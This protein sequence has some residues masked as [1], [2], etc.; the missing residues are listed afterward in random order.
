MVED[1]EDCMGDECAHIVASAIL[2]VDGTA[3]DTGSIALKVVAHNRGGA[4]AHH[5]DTPS[6]LGRVVIELAVLDLGTRHAGHCNGPTL[7]G[8]VALE[9][10]V[11]D[12]QKALVP[13]V[14]GPSLATQVICEAAGASPRL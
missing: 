4:T 6:V 10:G 2:L 12:C 7:R 9:E 8:R 14:D 5:V 13:H 11:R 3:R 1:K